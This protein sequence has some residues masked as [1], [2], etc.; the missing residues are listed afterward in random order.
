MKAKA[1]NDS[2]AFMD[3]LNQNETRRRQQWI[4][5]EHCLSD[6]ASEPIMANSL[7]VLRPHLRWTYLQLRHEAQHLHRHHQGGQDESI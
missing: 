6:E 1:L 5:D 2:L 3:F 7:G 4:S